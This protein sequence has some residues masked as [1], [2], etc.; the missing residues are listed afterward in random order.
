MNM[1]NRRTVYFWVSV[2]SAAVLFLVFAV[3]IMRREK[4]TFNSIDSAVISEDVVLGIDSDSTVTTVFMVSADTGIGEYLR[5][6]LV[7]GKEFV[8]ISDPLIYEQKF[9]FLKTLYDMEGTATESIVCW[10]VKKNK[11]E[12]ERIPEALEKDVLTWNRPAEEGNSSVITEED[13]P[14]NSELRKN[15]KVLLCVRESGSMRILDGVQRE[16]GK[17]YV[18]LIMA[19]LVSVLCAFLISVIF[20][21]A[22]YYRYSP[23]FITS[24]SLLVIVMLSP[25]STFYGHRLGNDLY[26][27][28]S[29]EILKY[30][31][32][33]AS[34]RI[35]AVDGDVLESFMDGACD[36]DETVKKIWKYDLD[37]KFIDESDSAYAEGTQDWKAWELYDNGIVS[38]E[39][40][41]IVRKDGKY[42]E[43]STE[44]D[45]DH[46]WLNGSSPALIKYVDYAFSEKA[47]QSLITINEGRR[48]AVALVP[49]EPDRGDEFVVATRVP[50]REIQILLFHT[51]TRTLY[52]FRILS[53]ISIIAIL[54]GI[55]FA[56]RPINKLQDAVKEITAGNLK[57]RVDCPGFNELHYL[58]RLFNEMA[59]QLEEQSEG[60]D[61]YRTFYDEFLPASLIRKMSGKSVQGSLQPGS[62][63][64]AQ[65]SCLVIDCS[66]SGSPG[67]NRSRFFETALHIAEEHGGYPASI[68]DDKIKIICTESPAAS[69]RT[70]TNIQQNLLVSHE[71]YA[72]TGIAFGTVKLCVIGNA[73]R[74][75]VIEQ[76]S[77]EAERLSEIAEALKIPVILSETIYLDSVR[78]TSKLHFRCLGRIG[79]DGYNP[80]APLYELLDA[81]TASKKAIREYSKSAFEKGVSAYADGDYFK[82]RNEMIRA[83]ELDPEDLAARCYI[84]NCDR[85]EPPTVC[86]VVRQAN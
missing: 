2:L 14:E 78:N 51:R 37:R 5:V 38:E 79:C 19:W 43:L 64:Q 61:S 3:V 57:A 12:E 40:S 26:S 1:K 47:A 25:F 77:D 71:P 34:M 83:L 65:A 85:K 54:G 29:S 52:I 55:Y 68:D 45:Q 69:L 32:N 10:N 33:S 53:T 86:Q 62:V 82:A 75:N 70:A 76:D 49:A 9:Y 81:E 24:I 58:A 17:K 59:E 4:F 36:Y 46:S 41:V 13:P 21:L 28:I 23:G 73:R 22:S 35:S 15:G 27:F 39:S 50:I 18:W 7:D 8:N 6:P 48:Y 84:L 66:N 11:L 72:W 42:T 56:I 20:S 80:D 74:K 60:T 16:P 30:C 44:R 67:E 63:Y 31:V